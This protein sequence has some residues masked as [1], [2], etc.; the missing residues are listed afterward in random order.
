MSYEL[1]RATDA[2][3]YTEGKDPGHRFHGYGALGS[4]QVSM[5]VI[6]LEPGAT[7]KVPGMA[8]DVGHSHEDI[9][10][11]YVVAAGE[12][13]VKADDDELVLGPLDAIRLPP[14]VKRATRNTG[15]ATAT[16]IMVSP[17]MRDPRAQSHFH[18]GFW[19]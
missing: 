13:T 4:E 8:D 19:T 15:D 16:V 18:E 7:H 3:D 9:D 2:P 17:K 14:E 1:L 6:V 5:N 12:V 10:E 11:V